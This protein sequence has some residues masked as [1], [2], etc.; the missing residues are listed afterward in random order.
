VPIATRFCGAPCPPCSLDL[1][2]AGWI[3]ELD[4]DHE[5]DH[6]HDAAIISADEHPVFGVPYHT[7]ENPRT[8]AKEAK[9][10]AAYSDPE[11]EF[12]PG[13]GPGEWGGD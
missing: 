10:E 9:R 4:L 13:E 8:R 3:C 11:L 2:G 1:P 6:Q 5:G 7:W 12:H